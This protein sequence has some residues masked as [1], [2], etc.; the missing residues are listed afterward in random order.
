[1]KKRFAAT[2]TIV[3]LLTCFT[4]LFGQW[5]TN[6]SRYA[7]DSKLVLYFAGTLDTL[8]QTYASLTSSKF[9]LE[10]YDSPGTYLSFNYIF[11]NTPGAPKYFVN[12]YGTDNG[13]T[14]SFLVAQL[15]DTATAETYLSTTTNFLNRFNE[16]YLVI[17][18]VLAGRDGTTFKAWLH[19][20]LKDPALGGL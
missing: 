6:H 1:M 7:D 17:A 12:L 18:Q 8:T 13:G 19:A 20:P 4:S 3:L 11:T 10:D 5:S 9:A 16:Y 15:V 2:L 14:N